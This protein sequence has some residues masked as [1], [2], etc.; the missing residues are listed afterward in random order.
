M[1][2][3]NHPERLYSVN[4]IAKMVG[5]NR[6]TIEKHLKLGIL[7][8]NKPASQWIITQTSF[9]IYKNPKN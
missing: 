1:E 8:G 5:V 2:N 6:K 9:N 7:K 4:Q 3:E